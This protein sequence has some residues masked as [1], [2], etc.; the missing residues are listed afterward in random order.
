MESVIQVSQTELVT[1]ENENLNNVP[2]EEHNKKILNWQKWTPGLPEK[3]SNDG[4]F[5]FVDFT[6]SWCITCQAN[7]LRV[8]DSPE[9]KK[10]F[11]E[12]NVVLVRADWTKPN[13]LIENEI[14]KFNRLGIP[15][16]IIYFPDDRKPVVL[17]EWLNKNQILDIISGQ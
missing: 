17:P 1:K 5:V 14:Q 10:F 2:I 9:I 11:L 7:K 8:I 16:N 4:K 3:I 12:K 6:A 13:K 15:L